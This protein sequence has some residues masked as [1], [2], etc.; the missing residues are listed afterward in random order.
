MP[1][2]FNS[3]DSANGTFDTR[4][5]DKGPEP[6]G[7]TLGEVA[8]RTYAFVGLERVGGIFIYDVSQPRRAVFV[9]YVNTRDFS[10]TDPALAG[11]LSPEDLDFIPA[12]DSPNGERIL[13]EG[14][15]FDVLPVLSYL[16]PSSDLG[17]KGEVLDM[18]LQA[19]SGRA[20]MA[21]ITALAACA[22]SALPPAWARWVI[23]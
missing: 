17:G 10:A 16:A 14:H 21:S 11:G 19:C 6:E 4:S 2:D 5:D 3:T 12:G 9:D 13:S 8:G 7:L 18:P 23:S 20:R 15:R 22:L 1:A